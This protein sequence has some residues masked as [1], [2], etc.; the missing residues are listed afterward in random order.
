MIITYFQCSVFW[1]INDDITRVGINLNLQTK[2]SCPTYKTSS[3]FSLQVLFLGDYFRLLV[4]DTCVLKIILINHSMTI[5]HHIFCIKIQ[6]IIIACE[7]CFTS[8]ITP[9][10]FS[11]MKITNVFVYS[12][13]WDKI[14]VFYCKRPCTVFFHGI[15]HIIDISVEKK[16]EKHS[17]WLHLQNHFYIFV[18][19]K[20]LNYY[21]FK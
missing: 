9:Y 4:P 14:H 18:I 6:F 15:R 8:Y 12:F 17:L 10:W 3:Y 11:K 2:I 19:S 20:T 21:K 1:T 7:I 5:N 16:K 13:I